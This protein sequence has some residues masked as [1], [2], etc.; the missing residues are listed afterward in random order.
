MGVA[1]SMEEE[2]AMGGGISGAGAV[3]MNLVLVMPEGMVMM[4]GMIGAMAMALPLATIV[5]PIVILAANRVLAGVAVMAVVVVAVVVV[6][7]IL[8]VTV[9]VAV[10]MGVAINMPMAASC[11]VSASLRQERGLAALQLQ[12]PLLQQIGQHR[13]LKQPKLT[14]A[15]LQG[16]MAVAE[17]ISR[18][19]QVEGVAGANHQQGLRGRLHPNRRSARLPAEPFARLQR[20]ATLQLQQQITPAVA[21]AMAAQP[22]AL[23]GAEAEAQPR[24]RGAGW[25]R[26]GALGE[27]EGPGCGFRQGSWLPKA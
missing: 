14:G 21:S 26:A 18:P 9:M 27:G 1:A 6:A 4:V 23:I 15:D 16:H 10:A 13:I 12:P 7:L 3:V 8:G 17:V 19:Q 22:G 24:I 20:G 5:I 25:R 2:S 11:G